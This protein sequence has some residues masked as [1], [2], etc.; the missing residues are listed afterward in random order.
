[1]LSEQAI[2]KYRAIYQKEFG[3]EISHDEAAEQ[4][5]RLLNL[6]RVVYQPMPKEW[7][8]RYN[9]LLKEQEKL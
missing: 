1:M 9:Q 2:E 7:L 5:Q 6:A 3:I 4:A 8:D